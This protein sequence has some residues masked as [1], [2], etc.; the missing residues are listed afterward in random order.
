MN[1]VFLNENW[2]LFN[3]RVGRLSATV[4]GCVHT[5]LQKHGLIPDYFWRDNN[6]QCQWIEQEDW[7]YSCVF[8]CPISNQKA[9]LHFDGLDTYATIKLNGKEM[10]ETHNMFIPHAFDVSGELKE[11]DNLLEVCF[12]SPV[13]EVAD[14]PERPAAFT[15][16]RL[17]TRRIQCTYSWD[18]VDR[19]VTCGI[20]L[21]V[22]LEIGDD[23]RVESTYITTEA[24]DSFGAQI[25]IE[26]DFINHQKT[27]I[28]TFE[29]L[30]PEDKVVYKH[31][32]YVA[33]PKVTLRVNLTKPALWWPN[34]Y[35]EHPLYTLRITANE[36]VYTE[37]FGVRTLRIAEIA[38]EKGDRNDVLAQQYKALQ[39]EVVSGRALDRTEE[40]ASFCVIVNGQRIYVRGGNWVPCSP[41]HS[42]ESEDKIKNVIALAVESNMNMIRVWAGGLFEK[43]VF[44]DECDRNGILVAQDFLMACGEYPE[45]EEWFLEELRKEATFAA[46][47]LRNHPCL[48]WWAGDNE[49]GTIG[50]DLEETYGGR[51]ASLVGIEPIIRAL[52][53]TR[54]YLRTSPYGG[55][56][57]MSVTRGTTHTTNYIGEMFQFFLDSDCSKYKE[58]FEH[59]LGRMTIEEPIFGLPQR[60][61]LLRFM[62]EADL[63]DEEEKILRFH[64]K[65]NPGITP[66]LYDFAKAFAEKGFGGFESVDDKLF[67]YEYMQY[68]WVRVIFEHCRRRIGYNDGL[69]FWMLND[70]WPASMSWSVID[71][72]NLPKAA[73]YSFKRCAKHVIGSLKKENGKY[74]LYVSSDAATIVGKAK[75]VCHTDKTNAIYTTEIEVK[76]YEAVTVELPYPENTRI[77]ICDI[78]FDGEKDRC[79]YKDGGL[80]LT[81][82]K[83][84][85]IVKQTDNEITL[86]ANEYVHAVQLEGEYVFS[87]NYFSMLGGEEITISYRKNFTQSSDES[88]ALKAFTIKD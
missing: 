77:A 43:D 64:C 60:C 33:E 25:C 34:G 86:K 8:D 1:K 42:E 3:E 61:S 45:T 51:N 30:S 71:F 10:G 5:D 70:A 15:G 57:Y 74:V 63:Y 22:Y 73:W 18:W 76:G 85:E 66:T 82:T 19:F 47:K 28:V 81:A 55:T 50:N 35:G 46:K 83:G 14:C 27:G 59:F 44:Y 58:H 20:F 37:K 32:Q 13:K 40:G 72:Y 31:A 38:D 2:Y 87:D 68:E 12:R 41:F 54:T 6:E 80:P 24:I 4:P 52:D 62:T 84:I 78:I 36:E 49:N 79:F 7:T 23:F 48:A 26:T 17:Y 75:I 39:K 56:P 29:I 11:K 16:E 53:P 21:P 65:T 9:V 69:I 67:K 88:L